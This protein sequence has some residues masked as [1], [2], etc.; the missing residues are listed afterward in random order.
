MMRQCCQSAATK[1]NPDYRAALANFGEIVGA[2]TAVFD[3]QSVR[4]YK[5]E[6]SPAAIVGNADLKWLE[7]ATV[8]LS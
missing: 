2:V 5:L 8:V 3:R 7:T 4:A 6:L 1:F